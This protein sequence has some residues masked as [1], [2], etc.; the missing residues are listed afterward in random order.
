[1]GSYKTSKTIQSMDMLT[2]FCLLNEYF[3]MSYDES[4]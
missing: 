2:N 3:G 4:L 1:M